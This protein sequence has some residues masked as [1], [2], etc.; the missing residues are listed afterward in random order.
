[1]T[2]LRI[3][4]ADDTDALAAVHVASWQAAYRGL[5]PDEYLDGL[6][7]ASR[8][9]IWA[10]T[11]SATEWPARGTLLAETDEGTV[12]GFASV[13]PTRDGDGDGAGEVSGIYVHPSSW[14]AGVGRQ[15]MDGAVVALRSAGFRQATLWVLE[16]NVRARDFYARTGWA[17][18]GARK[19]DV[20]AG[21]PVTEVRYRRNL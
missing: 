1:V 15:L 9:E 5:L 16:G 12:L 17:A 6:T 21:V 18:D 11:L 14:G 13:C 20:V 2:R 8:R 10:R 19:D 4:T 7:A 3:A